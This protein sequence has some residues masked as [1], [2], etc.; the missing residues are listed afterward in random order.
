MYTYIYAYKI[1]RNVAHR[2]KGTLTFKKINAI[3]FFFFCNQSV[4]R[5]SWNNH[6]KILMAF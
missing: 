6:S 5:V 3:L 1:A 2:D 4:Q